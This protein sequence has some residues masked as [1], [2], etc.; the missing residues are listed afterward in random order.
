MRFPRQ[1]YR[2]GLPCPPP[3]ALPDPETEPVSP[4]SPAWWADSLPLSHR[5]APCSDEQFIVLDGN[6]LNLIVLSNSV[7]KCLLTQGQTS[8]SLLWGSLWYLRGFPAAAAAKSLQSCQAPLSLGFSRQEHW[9]GLPLPS[10]MHESEKWKWSHCSSVKNLS[11]MR[12]TWVWSLYWKD[13]LK[14]RKA[15]YSSILAWRIP[16]TSPWGHKQLV[17]TEWLSFSLSLPHSSVSKESVCSAGDL[18]LT[19]GLERSPG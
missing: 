13:P 5:E 15:T 19:P 9:S 7:L 3:G 16:R 1:E 11:A 14:K 12:E 8:V 4:A 6:I 10:P 18:G 17:T 2:S